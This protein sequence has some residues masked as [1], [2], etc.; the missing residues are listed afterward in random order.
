VGGRS[1]TEDLPDGTHVH[2]AGTETA[3]DS[4][5]AIDGA[6]ESRERAAE[7]VLAAE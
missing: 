6:V 2:W 4:M 5:H 1:F 7:A 3:V